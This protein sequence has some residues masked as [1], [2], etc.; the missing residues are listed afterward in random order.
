MRINSAAVQA[1][2]PIQNTESVRQQYQVRVLKKALESQK[3]AGEQLLDLLEPKGQVL[4][5]KA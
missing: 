2:M 3:A 4:D 1:Q 5:I